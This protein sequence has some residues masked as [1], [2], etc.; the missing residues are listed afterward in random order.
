M[1]SE[2]IVEHKYVRHVRG[3]SPKVMVSETHEARDRFPIPNA[4][5]GD[6]KN[7]PEVRSPEVYSCNRREAYVV[8][9]ARRS[10]MSMSFRILSCR[11]RP[12]IHSRS[13]SPD[14]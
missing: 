9:L 8:V 1:Q 11:Q 5:V 14:S 13:A 6:Q 7:Y 4:R 3:M 12:L 2:R 10:G